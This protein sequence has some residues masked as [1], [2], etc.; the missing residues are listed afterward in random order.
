MGSQIRIRPDLER[1]AV[2]NEIKRFDPNDIDSPTADQ[3]GRIKV[4]QTYT[5]DAT[6]KLPKGEK[7]V[8]N[9]GQNAAG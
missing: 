1:Q 6:I 7:L 9:F 3:Y 4:K 5:K 2:D 8:I